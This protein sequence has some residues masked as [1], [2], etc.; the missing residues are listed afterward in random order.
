[1]HRDV[2]AQETPNSSSNVPVPTLAAFQAPSLVG[3]VVLRMFS[4]F[5]PSIA[6]HSDDDVQETASMLL[7][8]ESTPVC[9]VHAGVVAPG[10]VEETESPWL[11]VARQKET[12]GQDTA[13]SW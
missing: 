7:V 12:D 1:M 9:T 4:S 6:T 5:V 8:G 11:S 3:D 13:L 10:L 2:D